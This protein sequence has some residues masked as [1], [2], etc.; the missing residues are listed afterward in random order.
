MRPDN[1][2]LQFHLEGES[3]G[4]KTDQGTIKPICAQGEING[5]FT[6]NDWYI[7]VGTKSKPLE[8]E[9]GCISALSSSGYIKARP[10]GLLAHGEINKHARTEGG[11]GIGVADISFWAEAHLDVEAEIKLAFD[12]PAISGYIAAD[13]GASAGVDV[14]PVVGDDFSVNF[15]SVNVSGELSF[16]IGSSLCMA[17]KLT[18]EV[19]VL[20]Q[21]VDLTV[22]V[23]VDGGSVSFPEHPSRC[24]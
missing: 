6:K 18:G 1:G 14:E 9:L 19:T 2:S 8:V 7:D 17:G 22:G 12:N 5:K 3:G 11:F 15:A 4:V 20:G 10:T 24:N 21:G 13:A 23:K 16:M